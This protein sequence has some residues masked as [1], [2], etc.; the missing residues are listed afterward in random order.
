MI[1]F[2]KEEKEVIIA[3]L[4]ERFYDHNFG[5]L[6]KADIEQMMFHYFYANLK[7]NNK[8]RNGT[9]DYTNCSDFRISN[10]LG[11]TQQR[12]RNLIIKDRLRYPADYDFEWKS[13]FAELVENARFDKDTKKVII[14]IPDPNLFLDIEHFIETSGAY[15]E[16]QLNRKILQ[17]RAEFFLNL[18]LAVEQEDTR[19]KIVKRLKSKFAEANKD[20]AVF[21]ERNIGKS[22]LSGGLEV[23]DAIN[24]IT[25]LLSPGNVIGT[26]FVSLLRKWISNLG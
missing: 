16:T 21:D 6:S 22:L 13:A 14:S 17:I 1:Q 9:V 11:I 3:E 7:K 24:S 25:D 10:D 15:V 19:K 4:S 5:Q 8:K 18:V 23:L 2:S 12:V 20:N 26:A